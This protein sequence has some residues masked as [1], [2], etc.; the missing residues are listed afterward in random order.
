MAWR[1]TYLLAPHY[2]PKPGGLHKTLEVTFLL[3]EN[4]LNSMANVGFPIALTIFLLLR[5]E[6]K[7][8]SLT[9]AI[10][11]LTQQVKSVE[12]EGR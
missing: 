10:T 9:Q 4:L 2:L 7:L 6:S 3:E 5:M 8:E 12:Q 11:E 1:I